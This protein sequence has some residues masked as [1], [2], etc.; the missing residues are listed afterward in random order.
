MPRRSRTA[1]LATILLVPGTLAAQGAT[2]APAPAQWEVGRFTYEFGGGGYSW[3]TGDTQVG[4]GNFKRFVTKLGVPELADHRAGEVA[5]L[6]ALGAQGW[7]LVSCDTAH[8][9]GLM[10]DKDQTSCWLK[11]PRPASR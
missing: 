10:S 6:A 8:L 11:R 5:V 2:A 9:P 7:E 3:V 4:D 1:L